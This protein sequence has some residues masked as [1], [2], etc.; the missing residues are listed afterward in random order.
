MI[1]RLAGIVT[2]VAPLQDWNA[3]WPMLVR[4]S[5]STMPARLPE[6]PPIKA[7]VGI[8]SAFSAL[9]GKIRAVYE[10]IGL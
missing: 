10:V 9:T 7:W 5:G 6:L 3:P 1:V 4:P 2:L 8:G